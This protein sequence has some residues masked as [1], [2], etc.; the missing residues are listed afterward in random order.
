MRGGHFV[1]RAAWARGGLRRAGQSACQMVINTNIN[2]GRR[3]HS[4]S[5]SHSQGHGRRAMIGGAA[6][7]I[8]GLYDKPVLV[9]N[10]T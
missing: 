6:R 7:K 1:W 5:R 3:S 9:L 8:I 2:I 4:H 10:L